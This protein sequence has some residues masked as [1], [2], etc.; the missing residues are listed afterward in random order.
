MQSCV[1]VYLSSIESLSCGKRCYLI[2]SVH[3]LSIWATLGF[4]RIF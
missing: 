3:C 1:L 4:F 2:I